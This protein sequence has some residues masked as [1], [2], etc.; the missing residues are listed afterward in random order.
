MR[1][2]INLRL[3]SPLLA[4]LAIAL[5]FGVAA[6]FVLAADPLLRF[7]A[8]LALAAGMVLTVA[9]QILRRPPSFLGRPRRHAGAL[10]MAL[11]VGFL[12]LG[13]G[14]CSTGYGYHDAIKFQGGGINMN[15]S[16]GVSAGYIGATIDRV[17]NVD[18][19]G[20]A[21]TVKGPCPGGANI[22][23]TYANLNSKATASATTVGGTP[24]SPA[25][26]PQS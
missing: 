8:G 19:N 14:A 1:E 13:L 12:C 9:A 5:A 3:V 24:R 18:K 26:L 20:A 10:P 22:F 21:I 17:A 23:D 25:F 7:V 15:S 4:M 11:W 2:F 16:T 6:R